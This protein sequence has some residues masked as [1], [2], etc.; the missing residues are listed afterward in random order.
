MIIFVTKS[1][2]DSILAEVGGRNPVS[3]DV[4]NCLDMER[5]LDLGVWG[6]EEMEENDGGDGREEDET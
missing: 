5:F 2:K 6:N 4:M 1:C 3:Q